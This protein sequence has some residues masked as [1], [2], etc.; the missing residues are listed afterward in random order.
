MDK[1]SADGSEG[2]Y[3]RQNDRSR[4]DQT[5]NHQIF[6]D[7]SHRFLAELD[8]IRHFGDVIVHDDDIGCFRSD[9][10]PPFSH[11]DSYVCRGQSGSVVDA[12]AY[13][14]DDKS[15]LPIFLYPL[16]LGFRKLLGIDGRDPC[17]TGDLGCCSAIV[18]GQHCNLSYTV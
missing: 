12:I 7:D 6:T 18:S 2:A 13:H 16:I 3:H 1:S 10:G 17:L 8:D 9:L 14:P 5:G 4:I 11:G 15:F